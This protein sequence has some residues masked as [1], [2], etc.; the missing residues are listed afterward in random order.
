MKE[1]DTRDQGNYEQGETGEAYGWTDQH[2]AK[3]KKKGKAFRNSMIA[4]LICMLIGFL[5]IVW[6]GV[7]GG[8][9]A[10]AESGNFQPLLK[11]GGFA[12]GTTKVMDKKMVF[13]EIEPGSHIEKMELEVS[14]GTV[15]IKQGS[16]FSVDAS[17]VSQN[18]YECSYDKDGT[19]RI[20]DISRY[21]KNNSFF[22]NGIKDI[23]ITIPE[24]VV[25]DN[26]SLFM[27]AGEITVETLNCKDADIEIGA[28]SGKIEQI[29]VD[30][31]LNVEV[32]AGQLLLSGMDIK[33]SSFSCG[34][35]QIDMAGSSALGDMDLECGMGQIN[36][37]LPE[38]AKAY[39][40]DVDCAMGEVKIDGTSYKQYESVHTDDGQIFQVDIECG[41]GSVNVSFD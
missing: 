7:H 13:E 29:N 1:I 9:S 8:M 3:T 4:G 34:M 10:L 23:E 37:K 22:T 33:E 35:G 6:G 19:L 11:I 25:I 39:D 40:Y 27:G 20:V 2:D 18:L 15:Q 32:G 24:N 17:G 41:M 12:V 36:V 5:F 21:R 30:G 14:Y 16:E 28:G 38:A 26:L 31:K